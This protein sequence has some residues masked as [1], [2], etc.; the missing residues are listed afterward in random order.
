[1]SPPDPLHTSA[2]GDRWLIVVAHPDDET[3]GC[4][5]V[6]AHAARLGV[7]VTVICATRGEEGER[8]DRVPEGADLGAVRESELRR[9]AA[10]LGATGVELLGHRDSGFDGPLPDGAL[11]AVPQA[12]LAAEIAR[13]LEPRVRVVVTI[14]G[15]DGHRDHVHVRE[16]LR[17]AVTATPA[18]DRP[19][20]YEVGLPN[21]LMRR[22]AEEMAALEPDSPYLDID[23]E[24]LGTPDET[25]TDLLETPDLFD[26]RVAAIGT[27]ASQASP[28]AR[29]SPALRR[30]FLGATALVRRAP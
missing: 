2:S 30:E 3:F 23:P 10:M 12:D 8:S 9:A 18:T 29:L 20:H 26:L 14:D 25:I 21:S 22:W 16:A 1:M 27:H 5:S 28:F 19:A 4:G 17:V 11:C 13:H 7:G 15:S 24:V 6:I